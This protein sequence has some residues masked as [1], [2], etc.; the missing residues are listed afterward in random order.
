M[1]NYRH[2]SKIEIS[3]HMIRIL[4][5]AALSMQFYHFCCETPSMPHTYLFVYQSLTP[6]HLFNLHLNLVIAE[7]KWGKA[8]GWKFWFAITTLFPCPSFRYFALH[9]LPPMFMI[10][11]PRHACAMQVSFTAVYTRSTTCNNGEEP[12]ENHIYKKPIQRH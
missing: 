12:K 7:R 2:L 4:I 3:P 1:N 5:H 11:S 8:M 10:P 6:S 9:S